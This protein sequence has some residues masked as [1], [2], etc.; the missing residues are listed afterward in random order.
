MII[1]V[2]WD[3]INECHM[4]G[5]VSGYFFSLSHC[6]CPLFM[7]LAIVLFLSLSLS[8]LFL[9]VLLYSPFILYP[10]LFFPL[11]LFLFSP[12]LLSLF[13]PSLLLQ[14][15]YHVYVLDAEGQNSWL[16]WQPS[17]TF[18]HTGEI[19]ASAREL[20][21]Q[22]K[23]FLS[24]NG[25]C[26]VDLQALIEECLAININVRF[27]FLSLSFSLICLHSPLSLLSCMHVALSTYL[28]C[29]SLLSLSPSLSP[30]LSLFTGC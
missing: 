23:T 9:F 15:L 17:K 25:F 19:D 10:L 7:S 5:F 11:L 26:W 29:F 27:P 3:V 1:A 13:F 18:D 30:S 6:L 28:L 21:L 16:Q 8:S 12:P 24:F 22:G 2:L 20:S 4:E 14:T